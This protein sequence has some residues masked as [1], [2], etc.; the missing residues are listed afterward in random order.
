MASLVPENTVDVQPEAPRAQG[1]IGGQIQS[2]AAPDPANP[3]AGMRVQSYVPQTREVN[4]ATETTAGQ[5]DSILSKDSPLM[6]RART[7]AM[8]QANARGNINSS[9]A[10]GAGA[11]A[12]ID[13]A[14]PVAG[15]DAAIYDTRARTNMDA[16]NN[17]GQFN[18]GQNNQLVGQGIS[19]A[20]QMAEAARDREQQTALQTNA[21]QFQSGESALDRT[22]Q[23]TLQGSQQTFTA[24]QAE[25]ERTQQFAVQAAE[26]KFN[27][28][29]SDL[30]RALQVWQTD[31]SIA[32]Q[33]ALQA[34]EQTFGAAQAEMDRA[35]Q[36]SQADKALAAQKELQTSQQG[37][38][39]G[40]ADLD[41]AQQTTL[42]TS[43]QD[44]TAGQAD[45][46]REQQATMQANQQMFASVQAQLDREQSTALAEL[47]ANVQGAQTSKEFAANTA[48]STLSAI[49]AIQ[50]DPKL[51][52]DAKRAAIANLIATA[53]QTLQWGATFYG[54]PVPGMTS[55]TASAS[56][57]ASTPKAPTTGI[58]GAIYNAAQ[59]R[60]GDQLW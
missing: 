42:Q 32:A 23:T 11:G 41:R 27:A 52:P 6:R 5:L 4:R 57:T 29:Q 1:I 55:P 26:Q 40:Q 17:A 45:R 9:I 58:K 18:T 50:T 21:Q 48:S 16:V 37:F 49:N 56:T 28:A 3:T 20:A 34:A 53:N 35:L 25:R 46:D 36:V 33:Q 12:M 8:Q 60:V 15:A 51:K 31:R 30:A 22:Q 10:A 24:D 19:I 2:S 54:T 59:G 13:R 38:T 44:F 39:A 43:Q 14:T 7:I 47:Q